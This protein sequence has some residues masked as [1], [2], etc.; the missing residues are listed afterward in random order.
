MSRSLWSVEVPFS[1]QETHLLQTVEVTVAL[2]P[3]SE[4]LDLRMFDLAP[5]LW[6]VGD[7]DEPCAETSFLWVRTGQKVDSRY[8]FVGLLLLQ[9]SSFGLFVAAGPQTTHKVRTP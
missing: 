7:T 4:L 9:G 3:Q 6:F 2:P 8:S 5:R 1:R